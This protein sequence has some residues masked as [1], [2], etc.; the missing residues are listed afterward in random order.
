M[1]ALASEDASSGLAAKNGK[2]ASSGLRTAPHPR[3]REPFLTWPVSGL[4]LAA[5]SPSHAFLRS[6]LEATCRLS[7]A[8]AHVKAA[9]IYRCG[10]SKV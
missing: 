8:I 10:G 3:D 6:G 1:R 7:H 2:S 5:A 9:S 4:M